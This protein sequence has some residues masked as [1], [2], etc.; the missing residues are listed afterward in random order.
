[1]ITSSIA[2]AMCICIAVLGIL[3]AAP[4]HAEDI[5]GLTPEQ[6]RRGGSNAL[7]IGNNRLAKE[8]ATAL[9]L[10]QSDDFS[11]LIIKSRAERNLGEAK[12]A[13]KSAKRA[14]QAAETDEQ[15]FTAAM[16]RAQA[17]ATDG[18]H[19]A[20]QVWLRRA[21]Q[22]AP[23]AR[24]RAVAT[25]DFQYVRARNPWAAQ[26]SFNITPSNN[27]NN[28]SARETSE[29]FGLPF[30]FQLSGESQAL[31]GIE[32][33][34]GVVGRYRF[35]QT[36]TYAQDIAFQ[37]NYRT[38]SLSD[39]S[40]AQAPGVSGSDFAFGQTAI[41]YTFHKTPKDWIGP[42]SVSAVGGRTWYGGDLYFDYVQLSGTQTLK[43]S[44]TTSL[45][46]R[47]AVEAR[48]GHQTADSESLRADLRLNYRVGQ[49][50]VASFSIG[51]TESTSNDDL[52]AYS[53]LRGGIDFA[54]AKPVFGTRVS[55]G[56]SVRERDYDRSRY[57]PAGRN[58]VEV[59]AR[60]DLVFTELEQYGFNPTLT[61]KASETESNIGLFDSNRFGVQLGIRSAF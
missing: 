22:N 32:Y 54:L 40:K 6:L 35:D 9:L 43:L 17:L 10:R 60:L 52:N 30:E 4:S 28:G 29:L 13:V 53:E 34:T 38:Y 21:V 55:F 7:S 57:D 16:I 59:G 42:Y 12:E 23:D 48:E 15:R 25:R 39:A 36:A 37:A 50:G 56:L 47:G 11:A 27:I 24:A 58:D 3:G 33:S 49:L 61:I 41:G 2:K 51:N 8:I 18:N 31:E 14:W 26:L 19:T 1:M 20:S 46:F 5:T 44:A 45:S